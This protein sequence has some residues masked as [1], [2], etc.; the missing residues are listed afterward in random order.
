[1][2]REGL[3]LLGALL[4][5]A[6][7]CFVAEA[8]VRHDPLLLAEFAMV[9]ATAAWAGRMTAN[10]VAAWRLARELSGLSTPGRLHETDFRVVA[11][12]GMAAL[13][14]GM[15]RPTIYLGDEL[16][17]A[18]DRDELEAVILHESH[19]RVTYAPMRTAALDAW[20][21]LLGRSA[22][23]RARL[24]RRI[25]DLETLADAH[26]LAHGSSAAVLASALLKTSPSAAGVGASS[27]ATSERVQALLNGKPTPARRELAYEWLPVGV[28]LV[29]AVGCHVLG[30]ALA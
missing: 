28:A 14:T 24:R 10:A 29:A 22:T 26:A 7:W 17:E 15:L 8:Y 1:M 23:I 25:V 3:V 20:L 11:G 18:L 2:K 4:F 13:V 30:L 27:R 5:G 21:T 16:I 9:L 6:A 12:G 19:H